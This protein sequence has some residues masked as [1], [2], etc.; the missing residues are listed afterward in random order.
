MTT[1]M[2]ESLF[3]ANAV[4]AKSDYLASELLM[5]KH[6]SWSMLTALFFGTAIAI[7]CFVIFGT[8]TPKDMVSGVVTTTSGNIRIQPQSSG[9]VL[10]VLVSEGE[11]VN[12][13]QAL[14]ILGTSR[15]AQ[16]STEVSESLLQVLQEE[17]MAVETQLNQEMRSF[18]ER[19][20]QLTDELE[21]LAGMHTLT[22]TIRETA[23]FS[24]DI[25]TKQFARVSDPAV[26]AFTNS[27]DRDTA[28]TM[29]L[30]QQTDYANASL[31]LQKLSQQE[32]QIARE[33][34]A[35]PIYREKRRSELQAAL[36]RIRQ[37]LISAAASKQQTLLAPSEGIVSALS[38]REGQT[39]SSE[40]IVM[41]LIPV[42]GEFYL[43]L[44]IPTRSIG[45]LHEGMIVNIRY[46][47]FPHQ[48]F[49]MY[50]GRIASVARSISSPGSRDPAFAV[51]APYYLA[52]ASLDEQ[53]VFGYGK[54]FDLQAGMTASVDV[55]RDERRIIEWIFDPLLSA[56]GR[57]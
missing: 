8:Y 19:N 18:D 2:N 15:A 44:N 38:V 11:T 23:Q 48:T 41:S 54:P 20:A 53:Q 31:A 43:E 37:A 24:L 39:I 45:F 25:A 33:R 52:T 51:R 42:D 57:M 35:I 40:Q 26:A 36:A 47:A 5:S 1:A 17:R 21:R 10:N 13:G 3:R 9:I 55:R 7:L 29:L 50:S 30:K 16:R 28:Q 22:E 34:D 6:P 14:L 49:G 12:R 27:A 56:M 32:D 46:D 4:I